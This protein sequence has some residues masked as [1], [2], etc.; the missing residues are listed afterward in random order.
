MKVPVLHPEL[1]F[2]NR[3]LPQSRLIV[4][5]LLRPDAQSTPAY[6]AYVELGN[7][8]ESDL[9]IQ[10]LL[11]KALAQNK[12]IYAVGKDFFSAISS[13][14]NDVPIDLIPDH[15]NYYIAFPNQDEIFIPVREITGAVE[16]NRVVGMYVGGEINNKDELLYLLI[17]VHVADISLDRKNS[18]DAAPVGNL[19][20]TQV[21]IKNGRINISETPYDRKVT[22]DILYIAINLLAY[23][24]SSQPDI[25]WMR[26][27]SSMGSR[28]RKEFV[29][30]GNYT[31]NEISIPIRLVSWNWQ[32][33]PQY[34][35]EEW[36]RK[37]HFRWQ[38][39]GPN[40]SQAKFIFIEETVA[41]RKI[42]D[43]E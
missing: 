32:K 22:Q 31:S 24:N 21:G 25:S 27:K 1:V 29:A 11:W 7:M 2:G 15:F 33:P 16:P 35:K 39:F 28:E 10:A 37:A 42:K 3:G 38:R 5:E 14:K 6:R 8:S 40:L 19:I 12:K 9:K 4:K 30:K 34:T 17:S 13:V 26:P 20:A 43:E 36:K 18:L 41:K 23:I